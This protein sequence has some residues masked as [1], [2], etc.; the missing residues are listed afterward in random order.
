[1]AYQ[2]YVHNGTKTVELFVLKVSNSKIWYTNLT[3][4]IRIHQI[5]IQ[6]HQ[7]NFRFLIPYNRIRHHI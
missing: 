1:M 2:S 6:D 4:V 7:L 5:Y 3:T